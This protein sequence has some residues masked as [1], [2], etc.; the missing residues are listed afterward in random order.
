MKHFFSLNI[1]MNNMKQFLIAALLI[2]SGSVF[3]Q[4]DEE[5][6]FETDDDGNAYYSEVLNVSGA[7]ANKIY[8]RGIE[9]VNKYYKNPTGVLQVKDAENKII[10]G[11]ARIKL[12]LKDKKG[13]VTPMSGGFMAYQFVIYCKDGRYKYEIKRIR[14]EQASYYD[15]TRWT[16]KSQ[17]EYDEQNFN[18][19]IE[20]AIEYIENT[21]DDMSEYM[22][23]GAEV[24][25]DEW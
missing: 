10:E 12:K 7:D 9:W 13:N 6:P 23:H 11:K 4:N 15:V 24:K 25:K 16:D 1:L 8:T 14:W 2:M 20:Q 3:A 19:R 17:V 18:F 21:I 22:Q 5:S